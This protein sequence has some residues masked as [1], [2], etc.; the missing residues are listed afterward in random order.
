MKSLLILGAGG[1]GR[2]M[3]DIAHVLESWDQIAF[4]DDRYPELKATVAWPVIGTIQ[5]AG[6]FLPQFSDFFVAIG[7]NEMRVELLQRYT[8]E[9]YHAPKL[10]HPQAFVSD[11]ASM[12]PGCSVS[13][14]GVVNIN[15]RL[16]TGCIVNTGASVGHDCTLGNGVQLASKVTLGGGVTIDDKCMLGVGASV[17]PEIFI[18]ENVT[19]GAGATIVKNIPSNRTVVGVPGKTKEVSAVKPFRIS[20]TEV[21]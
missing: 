6:K 2:S 11:F 8:N 7:D 19:I 5:D 13:P 21:L 12:G 4:L 1:H 20:Q 3:A 16:G 17:I 10:I 9:G 14:Q 15:S 18:G